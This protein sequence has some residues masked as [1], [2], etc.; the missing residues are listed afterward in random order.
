MTEPD[1]ERG[2]AQRSS[3]NTL[4]DNS[5]FNLTP[6]GSAHGRA[7]N[8]RI[9]ACV[10]ATLDDFLGTFPRIERREVFGQ[11]QILARWGYVVLE[12]Q[13]GTTHVLR[14]PRLQDGERS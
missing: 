5:S 1:K 9:L 2:A 11:L 10:P 14:G 13:R 6:R 12:T 4:S 3:T 8:E 7:L